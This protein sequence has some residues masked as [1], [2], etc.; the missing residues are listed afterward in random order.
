MGY[1]YKRNERIRPRGVSNKTSMAESPTKAIRLPRVV[2]TQASQRKVLQ[3]GDTDG[4]GN[5]LRGQAASSW[6]KACAGDDEGEGAPDFL[7]SRHA[8]REA[9]RTRKN[10][11]Q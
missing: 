6:A 10:A 2:K 1:G 11:K 3:D 8:D 4:D 5:G 9:R 7:G